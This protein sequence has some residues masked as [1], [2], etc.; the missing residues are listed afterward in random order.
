M[1]KTE[2]MAPTMPKWGGGTEVAGGKG[3]KGWQI[4]EPNFVNDAGEDVDMFGR[5]MFR[6]GGTGMDV[7]GHGMDVGGYMEGQG[8]KGGMDMGG[9]GGMDMGG[10]GGMDMG[11]KGG[12]D[13]G[14]IAVMGWQAAELA[15]FIDQGWKWDGRGSFVR[16]QQDAYGGDMG[17]RPQ[18]DAYGGGM[19]GRPQQDA[20]GGGMGGN[21]GDMRESPDWKKWQPKPAEKSN[22]GGH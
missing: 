3:G 21:M 17:G 5:R 19:G 20:Y 10:K 18:Q 12:M 11:G 4:V 7:G 15:D 1:R 14:G 9:K 13:M 2:H 6:G 16:P 8:G 22:W